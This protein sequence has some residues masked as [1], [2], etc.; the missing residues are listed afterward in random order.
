MRGMAVCVLFAV[1]EE[2]AAGPGIFMESDRTERWLWLLGGCLFALFWACYAIKCMRRK[3]S[4][5]DSA[6]M[7]PDTARQWCAD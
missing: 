2:A 1:V 3:L 5:G 7:F 6:P 4:V